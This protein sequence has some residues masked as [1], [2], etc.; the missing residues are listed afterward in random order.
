MP[1]SETSAAEKS[2]IAFDRNESNEIALRGKNV[3]QVDRSKQSGLILIIY[4][5]EQQR[6]IAQPQL[7]SGKIG[8]KINFRLIDLSNYDLVNAKGFCRS[9][10]SNY[11][12]IAFIYRKKNGGP[13]IV[14]FIDIDNGSKLHKSLLLKGGLGEAFQVYPL[15]ISGYCL[16]SVDGKIK[17]FYTATIQKTTIYYRK[18]NWDSI[19]KFHGFLD[20]Y[21]ES[22][23][24]KTVEDHDF[25]F[26]LPA[27]TKWKIF[28]RLIKSNQEIWFDLGAFWIKYASKQMSILKT[29]NLLVGQFENKLS[30]FKT[31]PVGQDALID[32]VFGQET[33]FFDYPNGNIIGK[34]KDQQKVKIAVK[35]Q[36]DGID[37]YKLQNYG[38]IPSHYVKLRT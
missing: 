7:I 15:E 37:W 30:T 11:A 20:L 23:V 8:E 18:K 6:E 14:D 24:F 9:F 4:Q 33:A 35:T 34:I 13:L 36:I 31:T 29:E 32:F 1:I 38:W 16:I 28:H 21:R 3:L 22:A 2:V 19:E 27:K 10:F 12:I 26:K 25:L 5:D 17:G